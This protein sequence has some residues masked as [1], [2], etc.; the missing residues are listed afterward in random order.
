MRKLLLP[1]VL[2]SLMA[3]MTACKDEESYMPQ[4]NQMK[5]SIFNAYPNSVASVLIKVEDKTELNI[6][7]GGN[8]LYKSSEDKR[9]QMAN[10]LGMM[11]VRIFGKDSYLKTGKLTLTKD[12]RNSSITPTDGVSSGINIDSLEKL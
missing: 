11:T 12:E 3:G 2:I 5:D 4:I 7:L 6:V 10:E 8:N 1:C 9:Q